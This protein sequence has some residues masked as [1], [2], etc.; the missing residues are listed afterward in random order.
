[1]V[2]SP[3][4]VLFHI[5][6]TIGLMCCGLQARQAYAAISRVE[7]Q[8]CSGGYGCNNTVTFNT[9]TTAGELIVVEAYT[10]ISGAD[11]G[12]P[13]DNMGDTYHEA[14]V[15]S[16]LVGSHFDYSLWYAYKVPA[17]VTEVSSTPGT[18]N[19]AADLS[20][21]AAHYAGIM[22]SSDPLDV[23]S[24]T[25]VFVGTPWASPPVMTTQ[26]NELMVG[27]DWC[28]GNPTCQFAPTGN[29][30]MEATSTDDYEG[31]GMMYEDQIVSSVQIN[32]SSTGTGSV[33]NYPAIATFEAATSTPSVSWVAP[34]QNATVSSTITL[35]VSSTDGVAV[36]STAFYCGSYGSSLASSTLI[37]STST[38]S[39]TL[40]S[41]NWNTG[42]IANGSTTF[43]AL[44]TDISNS[45][46]SA[47]TT[48]NIENPP[49]ISSIA[50]N[51]S[52]TTSTITW[53]TNDAASSQ[54]NYGL[55]TSYG[56]SSLSASLVTSHTITLTNLMPGTTY[57][58]EVVSTDSQGNTSTST[59]AIFNT[60][61]DNTPPSTAS[62]EVGGGGSAYDL[63]INGGAQE[64]SVPN[65]ILFLYGT[66]AYT[67][68][69]S[70]IS[71]FAGV[72]WIPYVTAMPWTLDTT[73]G[74]EVVYAEFKSV[75][76]AILGDASASIDFAPQGISNE[77][78]I[79][80][81]LAT[82]QARLADLM[83]QVIP[84]NQKP[85]SSPTP[86]FTRNLKLGDQGPDVKMLQDFLILQ[87]VGPAAQA[88][89][90][91]RVTQTF[92]L[93]TYNAVKEFQRS[94]GLPGTGYFGPWTRR[95][96]DTL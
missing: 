44:A 43:W 18:G 1:M 59:D 85:L 64:T 10:G 8:E 87:N 29:W 56:A 62:I 46:S 75:Q 48:V 53:T 91:H 65:V 5:L 60:Q 92:G 57:H 15:Q 70:N 67:M 55:T 54:V 34:P 86:I 27:Q 72:T 9:S 22:T 52:L 36:S 74:P 78:S 50:S 61:P 33:Y 66:E 77:T 80:A 69:V 71:T 19:A 45:T 12:T 68:A 93:L 58:F 32:A 14:Y 38:A 42:S 11:I 76:G 89:A 88:L 2:V 94:V 41:I 23:S 28:Y 26:A 39:G 31:D 6:V 13:T 90:R 47:S 20:L 73:Q 30:I 51:A 84:L 83:A 37:G 16:N 40:Y 35:T 7:V 49:Q 96:A 24:S 79:A 21:I 25:A 63:L 4:R 17:G 95:E 3:K 81:E 82:L